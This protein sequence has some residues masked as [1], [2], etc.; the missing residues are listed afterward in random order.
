VGKFHKGKVKTKTKT[1]TLTP[2]DYVE[3]EDSS[4]YLDLWMNFI[5]RQRCLENPDLFELDCDHGLNCQVKNGCHCTTLEECNANDMKRDEEFKASHKTLYRN[6]R[7]RIGYQ[8]SESEQLRDLPLPQS[9]SLSLQKQRPG[10][11]H[12]YDNFEYFAGEYFGSYA[13][14]DME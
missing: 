6:V 7:G 10:K 12:A 5:G 9:Q 8:E 2:R 14:E 4:T 3:L 1:K 11:E 13:K